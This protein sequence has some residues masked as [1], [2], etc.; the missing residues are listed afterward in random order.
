VTPLLV[1][2]FVAAPSVYDLSGQPF[3]AA[4]QRDLR[5]L[6]RC[7]RG[8]DRLGEQLDPTLFEQ[9]EDVVYSPEQKRAL[10]TAWAAVYDYLMQ[11][12]NIRQR[13]WGFV[14]VPSLVRPLEH[15]WGYLL[16]HSALTTELSYGLAFADRTAGKKQLEVLLDEESWEYG[17]PRG[18]FAA[19]KFQSIHVA[20]TTQLITGDAYLPL[21]LPVLRKTK[22]D[23]DAQVKQ[24]IARMQDS[25]SA[26]KKRLATRGVI[27][28]AKNIADIA[29]DFVA[30]AVFPVQKNVAEW[31]GDTR[32]KRIGKPL[33]TR[34]QIDALLTRMLPGDII[35]ARQNWFLSN[36]GLP[37]FW[38]HAE[39]YL[40]TPAELAAFFDGDPD[41]DAWAQKQPGGHRTLTAFL[42]ATYPASWKLYQGKDEHGDSIRIM[43]SISEGVSLTG[44]EH[45]MRV[46]YLGVMRPRLSKL[47]KAQAIARAF[48][49]QGRPYDFDFDFFSDST[50]VCTELVFKSY[51]PSGLKL[52]LVEVAGRKTLPANEFVKKYD[53]E[54]GK[55]GAQLDLVAFL[56]GRED[57]ES[58]VAGDATT[59][60][61]THARLKWDVAQK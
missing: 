19:M 33:I 8:L 42:A 57:S 30:S 61:K 47:E 41:V 25:S 37:G 56:D 45:G 10:L 28:Y 54:L 60:R 48:G 58:A 31:M 22:L 46:D 59:F 16:T 5:E 51:A 13:W 50:L 32:V 9:P 29:K 39:L 53:A 55:P 1:A 7:A 34:E 3:A 27:L 24:L 26:A 14:T 40:G 38:P 35:V 36:I 52:G 11:A 23:A 21:L 12:E 44:V 4:A 20:T 2:A 43:E 17:I 6:E 15:A 18:A 49:Y